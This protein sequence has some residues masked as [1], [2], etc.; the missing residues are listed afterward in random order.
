MEHVLPKVVVHAVVL[1]GGSAA[2][3]NLL[4]RFTNVTTIPLVTEYRR[5]LH[6]V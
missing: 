3:A 4:A 6:P 2:E 5:E 1:A